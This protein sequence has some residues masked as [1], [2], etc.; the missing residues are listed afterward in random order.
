MIR[1]SVAVSTMLG[2]TT[3]EVT[4]IVKRDFV[5][6]YSVPLF[7]RVSAGAEVTTRV[8][9]VAVVVLRPALFVTV[10]DTDRF[11]RPCAAVTVGA[12]KVGFAPVSVKVEPVDVF[13]TVHR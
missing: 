12:V 9:G 11:T 8:S 2:L 5:V 10:N 13:V 6:R 4:L 3:D 1:S 7:A